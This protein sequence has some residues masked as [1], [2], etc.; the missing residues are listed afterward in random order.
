MVLR[1]EKEIVIANNLKSLIIHILLISLTSRLLMLELGAFPVLFLI[2]LYIFFGYK[3]LVKTECPLFVST[4][5]P[6]AFVI[7]GII[8]EV[9]YY[10]S[11]TQQAPFLLDAVRWVTSPW[12]GEALRMGSIESGST[13]DFC[14]SL[15]LIIILPTMSLLAGLELK[16]LVFEYG[17]R[18]Q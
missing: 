4:L 8:V 11:H 10:F 6:A 1:E 7:P 17:I 15:L 18:G 5:A 14:L 12:Y 9:Y 3:I 16:K 2:A 13:A